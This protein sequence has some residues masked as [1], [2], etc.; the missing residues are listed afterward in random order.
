[1]GTCT[2]MPLGALGLALLAGTASA[3]PGGHQRGS[4]QIQEQICRSL[5]LRAVVNY[6]GCLVKSAEREG[7]G[8]VC[9]DL[10]TRQFEAADRLSPGCEPLDNL[11]RTQ[12]GVQN[13]VQET[14]IGAI[15]QPPCGKVL[16]SGT[17]VTC[18]L[19][20]P[21]QL[22]AISSVNLNDV[23]TQVQETNSNITSNT[24]MWMQAWGGGGG[25]SK[26]YNHAGAGG[27][28]QTVT[29]IE[30]LEN[31]GV[32]VLYY[33]LGNGG[34]YSGASGGSGG[35][36]T[37]VTG[38]NLLL[39]PSTAPQ[40]S[41]ILMIAGGGGGSGAYGGT[42][43]CFGISPQY[44][45]SGGV[46]IAKTGQYGEGIGQGGDGTDSSYS[47]RGGGQG[48]GG[49]AAA[50]GEP[51]YSGVGGNGGH[52]GAGYDGSYSTPGWYN[53]GATSLTFT[54]GQGGFG[55]NKSGGSCNTGGGGGGGGWG[56]GGGGQHGN[57]TVHAGSG[58]GGGSYAQASTEADGNAPT[59]EPSDPYTEHGFLQFVFDLNPEQ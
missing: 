6:F 30:D 2:W 59:T 26:D 1:M 25:Q 31:Q 34:S 11:S 35:A 4:D 45:G 36:A 12:H 14:L 24:V 18:E 16:S 28:A 49:G 48:I 57:Q 23:L 58:G 43:G 7:N 10:F 38:Q 9:D 22:T 40:L 47:G 19:A 27:F 56:G 51:G 53:T 37:L 21:G 41:A 20:A 54:T 29:S 15:A 52:G 39:D 17:T 13:M 44:G 33:Y 46:A 32:D 8:S 42:N 3:Q 55:D 5:K 50:G